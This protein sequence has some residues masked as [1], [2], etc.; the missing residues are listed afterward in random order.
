MGVMW[1][2]RRHR[3]QIKGEK[4][5]YC[6]PAVMA[7]R[8][9]TGARLSGMRGCQPSGILSTNYNLC[10]QIVFSGNSEYPWHI[11]DSNLDHNLTI[12]PSG[13]LIW[14]ESVWVNKTGFLHKLYWGIANIIHGTI[15]LD[16]FI[17]T[18]QWCSFPFGVSFGE[19]PAYRLCGV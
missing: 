19:L 7:F 4:R 5:F 16:C 14:F 2:P 8:G 6:V 13:V 1:N 18:Q 17:A 12:T 15:K 9:A 3:F 10:K 11:P